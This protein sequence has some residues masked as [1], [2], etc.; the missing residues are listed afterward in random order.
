MRLFLAIAVLA[1]AAGFGAAPGKSVSGS[2]VLAGAWAGVLSGSVN[3]SVRRERIRI[4]VNARETAGTWQVSATCHGRLT[5][6]SISNGYHH[7]RRHLAAGSSCAGGDVDCL[8]REGTGVADVITP[9][10][11]GWARQGTLHRVRSD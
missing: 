3:G 5:L 8:E 4:F 10:P 11:G 6:D 9:R 2:R 1:A 7:Y